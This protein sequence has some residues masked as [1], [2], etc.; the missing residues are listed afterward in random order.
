MVGGTLESSIA[1]SGWKWRVSKHGLE[2][3]FIPM[4]N[5]VGNHRTKVS[6]ATNGANATG[7][8]SQSTGAIATTTNTST[9]RAQSQITDLRCY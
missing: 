6:V 8:G 4:E 2:T 7:S 1:P 5:G 9:V 3:D